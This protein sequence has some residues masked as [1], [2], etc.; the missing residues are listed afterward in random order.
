[1]VVDRWR[2]RS[3]R[4]PEVAG[5]PPD[6]ALPADS[7][8]DADRRLVVRAALGRLTDRQ[9][10]VLVLR[11]FE[12]LTE[13]QTAHVMHCSP[14]TVKSQTRH[15]LQRLRELAPELADTFDNA[16]EEVRA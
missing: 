11:V 1:M 7:F 3:R 13:T 4:A 9:R 12:D 14:S 16:S 8:A 6:A 5:E 10:Q 15:A 2:W